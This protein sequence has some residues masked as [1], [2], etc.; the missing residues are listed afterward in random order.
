MLRELKKAVPAVIS[1]ILCVTMLFGAAASAQSVKSCRNECEKLA[2]SSFDQNHIDLA[3]KYHGKE[4]K[5]TIAFGKSRAKKFLKKFNSKLLSEKS[6]FSI[7]VSDKNTIILFAQKGGKVKI[8]EYFEDYDY[9][10]RNYC[11]GTAFFTDGKSSTELSVSNKTK[12]KVPDN[13]DPPYTVSDFNTEE[14]DLPDDITGKYFKF[15]SGGKIYYYEA[16]TVEDALGDE[17]VGFL[18]DEKGNILAMIADEEVYCVSFRTKVD[19]SEF[20]IPK[21]YKTV[22]YDDFEY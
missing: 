17:A 2:N 6:E 21:G 15:K 12:T 7:E 19:D 11:V 3:I 8:V 16:F 1:A 18:F 4:A 5:N 20:D 9:Y 22:D 13:I 14:F 10:S